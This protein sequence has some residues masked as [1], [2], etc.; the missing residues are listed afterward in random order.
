MTTIISNDSKTSTVAIHFDRAWKYNRVGDTSMNEDFISMNYDDLLWRPVD[1][2]HND[3]ID[4]SSIYWYRKKFEWR[5]RHDSQQHIYLNFS[6]NN[7]KDER[8]IPAITVWLNENKIYSG[9]LQ[10][11]FN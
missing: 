2:P 7:D 4:D 1:L 9:Y 5:N 6:S 11:Q 10:H 3:V 8:R